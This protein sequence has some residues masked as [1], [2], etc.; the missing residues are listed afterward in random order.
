MTAVQNSGMDWWFITLS[1][2]QTSI[3]NWVYED[4]YTIYLTFTVQ[5]ILHNSDYY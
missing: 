5:I 1:D 2:S 3:D 4:K